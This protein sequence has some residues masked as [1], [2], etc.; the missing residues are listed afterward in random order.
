MITTT[1]AG[2]LSIGQV[3]SGNV[4]FAGGGG[5]GVSG[6]NNVA[7]TGG[8]GGGTAGNTASNSSPANTGGGSGGWGG[9]SNGNGGS[10]VVLLKYPNSATITVP[11]GLTAQTIT[12]GSDKITAFK[13]GTGTI[14][15]N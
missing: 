6:G 9:T 2:T 8:L 12:S 3:D 15:F 11:S 5:G 4:Y 7:G 14:T 13:S 10:G 1:E